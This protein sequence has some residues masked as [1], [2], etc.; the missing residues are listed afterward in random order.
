LASDVEGVVITS[1]DQPTDAGIIQTLVEAHA[2]LEAAVV[3]PSIHHRR[4]HPGL[5]DRR[6]F[7]EMLAITEEHEGLR[8]V[9]TRHEAEICYV[10]VDTELVRTNLNSPAEYEAAYARWGQA[11]DQ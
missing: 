1:V 3:L 8:E 9:M 7:P 10:N 4:G 11:P 6:L 5:F 2:Q